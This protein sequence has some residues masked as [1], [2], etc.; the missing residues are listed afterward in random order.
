MTRDQLTAMRDKAQ[1]MAADYEY[2]AKRERDSTIAQMQAMLMGMAV[3]Q[4]KLYDAALEVT[5]NEVI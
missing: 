4:A 1:A 3:M 5:R 2:R